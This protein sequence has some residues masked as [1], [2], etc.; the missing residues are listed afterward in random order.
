[1]HLSLKTYYVI[2]CRVTDAGIKRNSLTVGSDDESEEIKTSMVICS[3]QLKRLPAYY[4][5]NTIVPTTVLAFL[6]A[7]VFYVPVD[8]G[9]KLSVS[10]MILLSFSVFLLIVS[11]NTPNISQNLPFLGKEV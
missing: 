8:A 1:M 4:L 5:L 10:I 3:I 11:N 9:E 2:H 6:S 7:F